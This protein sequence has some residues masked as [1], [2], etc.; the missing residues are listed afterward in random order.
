MYPAKLHSIKLQCLYH[1]CVYLRLNGSLQNIKTGQS[2]IEFQQQNKFY[3]ITTGKITGPFHSMQDSLVW[4]VRKG[5]SE[6]GL[7]F[8]SDV[9]FNI[10]IAEYSLTARI[11]IQTLP[12][13]ISKREHINSCNL[14]L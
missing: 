6:D 8:F 2:T 9:K 14:S 4:D 7:S 1:N 13:R 10:L 3:D 11:S 12:W 5:E